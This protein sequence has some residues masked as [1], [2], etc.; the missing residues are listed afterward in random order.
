M[1][2]KLKE[3]FSE[4]SLHEYETSKYVKE[5]M[6]MFLTYSCN[7]ANCMKELEK[8]RDTR[9]NTFIRHEAKLR[10]KKEKLW[11]V[12]DISKW[13]MRAEDAKQDPSIYLNNK[14][15]ALNKMLNQ[16]TNEL[17][18]QRD[19]CAHFNYQMNYETAR[20]LKDFQKLE[21]KHYYEFG[22][23]FCDHSAKFHVIWGNL[24][25]FIV[26]LEHDYITDPDAP[27]VIYP[28]TQTASK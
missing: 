3:S 14:E 6:S 9:F 20:I 26:G 16:E 5:M 10:A 22:R 19:E 8:E 7:E 24:T 1:Y 2:A 13:G 23:L 18:I 28:Q 17:R 15:L 21:C 11:E 25:A 12:A 27:D 4:W